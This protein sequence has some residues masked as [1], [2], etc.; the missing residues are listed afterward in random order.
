MSS[1]HLP[2]DICQLILQHHDKNYLTPMTGNQE[3]LAFA[4]LKAAENM[5]ERVKRF[6]ISPDWHLYSE[7]VLSVL[8]ISEE[9]YTDLEED[10]NEML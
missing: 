9:D 8:G 4:A 1:W 5:A 10:Y 2:K 3:Q 7:Q 6:K